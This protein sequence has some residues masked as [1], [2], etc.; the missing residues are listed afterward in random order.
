MPDEPKEPQVAPEPEPEPEP[1]IRKRRTRTAP[2][3]VPDDPGEDDPIVDLDSRVT[4]LEEARERRRRAREGGGFSMPAWGWPALALGL[5]VGLVV[6]DRL[7]GRI[8][9][10]ANKTLPTT[11]NP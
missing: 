6:V 3:P 10:L 1:K 11:N 7:K 2:P 8:P 9:W 5:L 4:D